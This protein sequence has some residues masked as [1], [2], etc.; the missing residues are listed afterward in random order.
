MVNSRRV[1]ICRGTTYMRK[2]AS[3]LQT[4]VRNYWWTNH[5]GLQRLC[6]LP[7]EVG[8]KTKCWHIS[9]ISLW[10][11]SQIKYIYFRAKIGGSSSIRSHL[12]VTPSIVFGLCQRTHAHDSR[13][14]KRTFLK[15]PV[16]LWR[17]L[18]ANQWELAF[19]THRTLS[20]WFKL[21]RISS[22]S[23]FH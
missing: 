23:L 7:I 20:Y 4:S 22:L 1:S 16:L 11:Q 13:T 6:V 19:F 9:P 3:D 15:A 17:F 5:F 8:E 10:V 12:G 2:M 21:L 14:S 18:L